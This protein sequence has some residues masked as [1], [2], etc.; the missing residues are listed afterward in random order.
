MARRPADSSRTRPERVDAVINNFL[1]TSG[2]APRV[3]QATVIAE[4]PRLVG[5]QVAAVTE[6][7]RVT[8]NGTLFVAVNSNPWM[9]ELSLL[10]P[11]LLVAINRDTSRPPV[12]RIRWQARR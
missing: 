5:P 9:A 4:W 8:A 11:R 6:P 1:R 10:E 12:K 3:T 7:L 2:L